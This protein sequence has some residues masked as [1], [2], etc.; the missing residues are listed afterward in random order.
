[1]LLICQNKF[2]TRWRLRQENHIEASKKGRPEQNSYR[3]QYGG[4]GP[5]NDHQ[6]Q[7]NN[8]NMGVQ[9]KKTIKTTT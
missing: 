9:P 6:N 5:T 7:K 3:S 8:Q 1:M 4:K 2:G